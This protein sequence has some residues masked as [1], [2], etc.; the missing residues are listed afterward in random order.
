M[1]E[2]HLTLVALGP[3]LSRIHGHDLAVVTAPSKQRLLIG[4]GSL[5]ALYVT[6][7]RGRSGVVS[8]IANS[9]FRETT[10]TK[11]PVFVGGRNK[12][13]RTQ[14][15]GI[16]TLLLTYSGMWSCNNWSAEAH[17][18]QPKFRPSSLPL[19][20]PPSKHVSEPS[21]IRRLSSA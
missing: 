21:R 8:G 18:L 14:N 20:P 5:S 17:T 4:L 16:E 9:T 10:N 15:I 6:P 11:V 3:V 13:V 1:L 2:A 19:W 12:H 7:D